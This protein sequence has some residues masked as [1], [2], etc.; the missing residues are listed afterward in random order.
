MLV[1][2]AYWP[3]FEAAIYDIEEVCIE[4]Q[5]MGAKTLC[6]SGDL[7]VHLQPNL[8]CT[9]PGACGRERQTFEQQQR[10]NLTVFLA[11]RFKLRALNTYGEVQC[12]RYPWG[13]GEGS[14]MDYVMFTDNARLVRAGVGPADLPEQRPSCSLGRCRSGVRTGTAATCCHMHDSRMDAR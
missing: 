9:G 6:L 12:A 7:Q 1:L 5:R 11:E 10:V 14:V 8:P 2:S 13:G 4:A 3:E